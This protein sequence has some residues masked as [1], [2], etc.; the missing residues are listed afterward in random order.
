MSGIRERH[1]FAG[2]NTYLGFFS[3]FDH[4]LPH[5]LADSI[6]V[7]KGGPGTGKSSFMKKIA[8][9]MLDRG[10]TVEFI[11]CS[12]DSGSLDAVVIKELKTAMLDGTAPHITDP[13]FPGAVD[14]I[15]DFGN[16]WNEEG[17]RSHRNEITEISREISRLFARAYHY[18]HAAHDI[19]EDSASIHTRAL[20]ETKLGRLIS[21]L[22]SKLFSGRE[23]PGRPGRERSLFASAITPS[24]LVNFLDSLLNVGTVYV[25]RGDLGTGGERII[26]RLKNKALWSGYDVE[27]F[28]CALDPRKPEHLL[29][30]GLDAAITV[31]NSYH[32][33]GV[34]PA[35]TFDMTDMMDR[36]YLERHRTELEENC[37]AFETMLNT[38]VSS[39]RRAKES[40]DILERYYIPYMDFKS[41]EACFDKI[42]KRLTELQP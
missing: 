10:Y 26:E 42:L 2:G 38:A 5:D 29:I 19:R 8:A 17:I 3:Y 18:L 4:I 31:S 15:L 12:S 22:E 27:C 6:Y 33:C 25:I 32:S 28:Y 30:P 1:M 13:G 11:H 41:V 9:A 20:D 34:L 40:H 14:R 24:G 39:I 21:E 35:A 23:R 37:T 36:G 16:F 7:I